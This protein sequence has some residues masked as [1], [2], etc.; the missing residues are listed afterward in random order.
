PDVKDVEILINN[1]GLQNS[2]NDID[3]NL[4]GT[5]YV[6]EK[7][8]KNNKALKSILFNASASSI[9]G[10]EFPLYAASKAGVVG[11]MKNVAIRLA[12]ER[13]TVNAISLG[14]V[15]TSL[16]KEVME[17]KELWDKIMKVTPMKKWTDTEEVSEWIYFLT[18]VNKS[19]SG[20]NI[21][22][23]NGEYELNDNFVWPNS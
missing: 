14:G 15:K 16:N 7:Y 6:T 20:Q 3:N 1:A 23:D 8:I 10:S 22:I 2:T 4:K 12:K 21:L 17:N 11:Y 13:V 5:I 18:C 9:S 19:A